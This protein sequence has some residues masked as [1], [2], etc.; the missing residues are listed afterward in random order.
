MKKISSS[1][2]V[3]ATIIFLLAAIG[4]TVFAYSGFLDGY[5][6]SCRAGL[7][8]IDSFYNDDSTFYVS[9]TTT[10]HDY[11]NLDAESMYVGLQKQTWYGGWGD[12][13][14][15]QYIYSDTTTALSYSKSTG[16]YRMYFGSSPDYVTW[17]FNGTVYDNQ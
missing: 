17:N 2:T 15:K 11:M 9:H 1:I 5:S 6:G 13:T 14:N 16:T 12:V 8:A 3:L 4:S 7:Y 10:S